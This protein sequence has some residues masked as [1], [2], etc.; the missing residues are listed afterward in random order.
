[1][2]EPT[3]REGAKRQVRVRRKGYFL[4]V[5]VFFMMCATL[6]LGFMLDR[7]ARRL[8]LEA[9]LARKKS[10][11]GSL[12]GIKYAEDRII[13]AVLSE[14]FPYARDDP[15]ESDPMRKIEAV[16]RNGATIDGSGSGINAELYV[17]DA[18]YEEGLFTGSLKN[19]ATSPFVPVI[20]CVDNDDETRRFYYLRSSS[21]NDDGVIVAREELLAVARDKFT[22]K[23]SVERIFSRIVNNAN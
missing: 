1:M 15:A 2:N 18:D 12:I 6:C 17:A 7:S 16:L 14:G 9:E 10:D 3:I 22:L 8:R 5:V 23:V 19:R 4:A 20:P 11:D 13:S 21:R